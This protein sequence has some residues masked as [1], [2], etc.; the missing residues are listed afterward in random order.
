[1]K[2]ACAHL[3]FVVQ[4]GKVIPTRSVLIRGQIAYGVRDYYFLGKILQVRQKTLVVS[5]KIAARRLFLPGRV[6]GRPFGYRL[7]H[8]LSLDSP[9]FASPSGRNLERATGSFS[10]ARF[11]TEG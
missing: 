5:R 2:A 1:M 3:G 9:L 4:A 8:F 6:G 11:A 7:S 10:G